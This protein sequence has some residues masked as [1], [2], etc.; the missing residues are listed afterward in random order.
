MVDGTGADP[1]RAEVIVQGDRILGLAQ[2]GA[3]AGLPGSDA[4]GLVVAPGFIDIHTHSDL[5]RL[6]YPDAAT[7]VLQGITTEVI[8]NCG[9]S[10]APDGGDPAGLRA[11]V[12]PIDVVPDGAFGWTTTSA[13]LDAL[14]AVPG[15][16][17]L[18][19]LLGHGA[20]RFAVVGGGTQAATPSQR[21]AMAAML[22]RA[23]REGFWGLSLGLMYAPGESS[24]PEELRALVG[25][26][27]RHPGA[28]L[29][30]HL[31]DYA[32]GALPAAIRE[33]LD[34]VAGT[35]V[36]VEISHLRT[37]LDDGSSIAEAL[38][39]LHGA[40]A[41]VEADAYPYL[42]G[43]TTLLQLL[44]PALRA[45]GT[46]AVLELADANPGALADA[47]RE[48]SFP[49]DAITIAKAADPAAVGRDLASLAQEHG[50]P[51]TVVAERLTAVSRGNVDVIVV[52]T[53]P[54]D[55]ARV[56]ADP[57]VSVASD[58]VSL[59][60]D[61]DA[62]LP[63]P[64]SIG[65]FPRALRELLDA[66]IPIAE[67]VRKMTGKPAARIG[68]PDRGVLRPGAAA[69]LVVLDP[70]TVADQ[71]TYTDPLRPPR[72]IHSVVVAG[73]HVLRDGAPTGARPG[74]LLRRGLDGTRIPT[75]R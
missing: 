31:R 59:A 10:P 56:L 26:L 52:G 17:N 61:H 38:E 1:V 41:D 57:L 18:A 69:D 20:V 6:R 22:D 55:A 5:T 46:A 54:E 27:D 4:T 12:G 65:T 14:D 3:A 30:A 24:G 71:A 42:A 32:A 33:V 29:S 28:L 37:L 40:V 11:L 43:H 73:Q 48:Q 8:G 49:P 75:H 50:E 64:R 63:H 45:R 15:A 21:D 7:R 16:T 19:P 67:A 62:N 68:L 39:L 13:F 25:V 2:P 58:G 44:P 36:P 47:F 53:R 35:S 70:E 34:L 66:G 9:L 23:L 51:W 72:G 60:L 74:R